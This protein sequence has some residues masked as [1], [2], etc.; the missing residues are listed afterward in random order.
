[1]KAISKHEGAYGKPKRKSTSMLSPYNRRSYLHPHKEEPR[2]GLERRL[3]DYGTS[4]VHEGVEE[5][6]DGRS[7]PV[8]GDDKGGAVEALVSKVHK[9]DDAYRM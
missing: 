7:G 4:D 1:M 5:L 2:V 9:S 3:G 8:Q 6:A